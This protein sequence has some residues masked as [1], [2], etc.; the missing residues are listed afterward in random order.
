[1]AENKNKTAEGVMRAASILI[2]M[3]FLA[4]ILG[5][6]RQ[7]IISNSFGFGIES[8]AYYAAFTIPDLIYNVLVGGGLSSAFIPVF[9]AYL[10][11]NKEDEG[12]R[13]ASTILNIV[14]LVSG[15]ASIVGIIFA[16]QLLP[17]ICDFSKG[18]QPF[19]ELTV[20]LTRIMFFQSFFMC[21]TGICMGILQ[22][23]KDF[24]PPS[25][26]S[27][28]YNLVIIVTGIILYKLGAGIAGFSIG[29]VLGS[30]VHFSIQVYCIKKKEFIYH[31][32]IDLDNLGVRRFFKLF[33]PM[34][35]GISVSQIN[36]IVNKY[37]GMGVAKSILSA[38]QNAISIQQLP[39]NMFGF[40]IAIS[41][42]PTMVEHFT[43][44]KLTSYKKDLSMAVRNMVFITLP[45]T[46]GLISV[47]VPLIRALYLHGKFT[48][49]DLDILS[50]LLIFYCL[51]ITAYCVRQVLLQAFY[52]LQITTI[53]VIINII[54]LLLNIV[55]SYIFVRIWG[56]NGLGLAYS[57]AGIVSMTL[58]FTT[59]RFKVGPIRG[60]EI[61]NSVIRIFL[62]CIIM[63][64][65]VFFSIK[66]LDKIFPIER[67]L[68][69]FV[70]LFLL[71]LIA[72]LIYMIAAYILKIK[73][74]KSAV[75]MVLRK[76][77]KKIKITGDDD[78]YN[79]GEEELEFP[80]ILRKNL[81]EKKKKDAEKLAGII[82]DEPEEIE[83]EEIESEEIESENI[84]SEEIESEEIESEEIES[85]NIE[86]EISDL[87][88][89]D[90]AGY[91]SEVINPDDNDLE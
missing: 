11:R 42:F 80:E 84:E 62:A 78:Y 15:I 79:N 21:L 69:Q 83:S 44:N 40:S 12:F 45:A 4:S 88:T 64:I 35:L 28:I 74:L 89:S 52:S 39:I 26:G 47:R 38:M 41:V 85:E 22:A 77:Y 18:G 60:K 46:F 34:L 25:L 20:K 91:A 13:M 37:F 23:Y 81:E 43:L 87:E 1:M 29:V 82:D 16:P 8:D 7:I 30:I 9:S 24:T 17:L 86:S 55:L 70:E 90:S 63:Y 73:E 5:Y 58:L 27:V 32:L 19:F 65:G 14:A 2:I 71:I 10:T 59:L 3:N 50:T 53:P 67:K 66:L 33:W 68:Y 76:F 6:A 31:R 56:A 54:I 51:G 49:G 36:T 61:L 48:K 75:S 72:V 57:L